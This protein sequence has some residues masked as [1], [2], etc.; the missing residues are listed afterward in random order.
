MEYVNKLNKII[1]NTFDR[2]D[3]KDCATNKQQLPAEN[4][5][6]VLLID[7]DQLLHDMYAMKFNRCGYDAKAASSGEEAIQLIKSGFVPD[8]MLIDLM[9]PIMDG[10]AVF[11]AIKDKNLAPNAVAIMLT[12]KGIADEIRKAK[13]IGFHSFIIKAITVPAEVVEETAKIY[14]EYCK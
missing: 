14:K 8:I 12:N 7:D 13:D 11:Q 6:K 1:K 2:Q 5:K 4:K 10:F 3:L 9:I